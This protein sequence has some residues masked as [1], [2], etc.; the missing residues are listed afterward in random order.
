MFL[1]INLS[2]RGIESQ[3]KNKDLYIHIGKMI[4]CCAL[5]LSNSGIKILNGGVLTR[6]RLCT[7]IKSSKMIS[8]QKMIQKGK[9]FHFI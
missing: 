9:K 8:D 4:F 3:K 7:T 2:Q 5:W 6:S 1:E